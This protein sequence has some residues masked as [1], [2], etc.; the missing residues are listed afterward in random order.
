[1]P[2]EGFDQLLGRWGRN[3]AAMA[4][5]GSFGLLLGGWIAERRDAGK[6]VLVRPTATTRSC[7][8]VG[9]AVTVAADLLVG[10]WRNPDIPTT[11]ILSSPS[12]WAA[13][14][15]N[16]LVASAQSLVTGAVRSG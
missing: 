15:F 16:A 2:G 1:M 3:A 5:I 6:P 8:C 13:L 12:V 11:F 7:M 10:F 14:R 9:I 4:T